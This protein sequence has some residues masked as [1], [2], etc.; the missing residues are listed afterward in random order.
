M[1]ITK[2]FEEWYAESLAE[3]PPFYWTHYEQYLWRRAGT[4]MLS[5][6]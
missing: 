5:R 6:T 4:P 3:R 2:E 1:I